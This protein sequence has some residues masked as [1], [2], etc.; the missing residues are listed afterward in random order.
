MFAFRT[1]LS[2]FTEQWLRWPLFAEA[3]FDGVHHIAFEAAS[4]AEAFESEVEVIVAK[5]ADENATRGQ[6]LSANNRVKT[7]DLASQLIA[8]PAFN[9]G[10]I[11]FAK[12]RFLAG[13]LF[14]DEDDRLLDAVVELAENMHWLA[15][16]RPV[17]EAAT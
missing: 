3:V 11:S 13:E 4:W 5:E 15:N 16:A 2:C 6:Q 17:G 9:T 12:R 14:P 10:R 8:D 7:R 1:P